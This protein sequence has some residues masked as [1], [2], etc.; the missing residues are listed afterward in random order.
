MPLSS[1]VN[2]ENAVKGEWAKWRNG[3]GAKE[4]MEGFCVFQGEADRQRSRSFPRRRKKSRQP[5]RNSRL[6]DLFFLLG[7]LKRLRAAYWAVVKETIPGFA[8]P[9]LALKPQIKTL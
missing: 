3:D 1:V 7:L 4:P 5:R 9:P 2:T 6:P 8:E